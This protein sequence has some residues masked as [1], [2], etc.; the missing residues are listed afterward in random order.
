MAVKVQE[1]MLPE[2]D[3]Y[4]PQYIQRSINGTYY[5]KLEVVGNSVKR[6]SPIEFK[7]P[8]SQDYTALH[9]TKLQ[10]RVKVTKKS[11]A[12]VD[13]GTTDKQCVANNLLHTIFENVEIHIN[14]HM[15]ENA[16]G[17]YPYRAF[18]DTLLSLRH[19]A[20]D[21]RGVLEGWKKDAPGTWATVE[22]P[23]SGPLKDR[24]EP[25]K[26]STIVTLYGR[27][28]SDIMMQGLCIPPSTE[29]KIRLIP[30]KD[31]FALIAEAGK[32]LEV[33]IVEANLW[34]A[35][36]SASP[37]LQVAHEKMFTQHVPILPMRKVTLKTD[38]IPA[39]LMTKKFTSLFDNELPDR[40]ILG[41]LSNGSKDGA[42]ASNPFQFQHFGVNSLQVTIGGRQI[43]S[44]AYTPNFAAGGDY[45]REYAALLEELNV[46]E[47]DSTIDISKEEFAD[48]YSLF[49]FRI[50]PRS[51]GGE[52]LAAPVVGDLSL[53]L[54]FAAALTEV[55]NVLIY[56]ESRGFL[57][58]TPPKV[59]K[60]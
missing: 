46:D 6:G 30:A 29:I 15:K 58:I 42:L 16:G 28:H 19:D 51:R 35:R 45:I 10:I 21:R 31:N 26:S 13:A 14:G 47:G 32:E 2:F 43:P 17:L 50:V 9:D 4:A 55:V 52:I 34:V 11:A 25:F 49:P 48:G 60:E 27:I 39:G 40:F 38:T 8:K 44:N 1:T 22:K 12:A 23:T 57:E 7:I 20:M 56:Y 37:S 41:F 3:Y 36:V 18:L 33:H 5:D 54:K 59:D 24:T 53:E